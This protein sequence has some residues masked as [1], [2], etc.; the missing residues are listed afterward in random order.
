MTRKF[1]GIKVNIING[2][3][4]CEYEVGLNASNKMTG[5]P[6]FNQRLKASKGDDDSVN[7][8]SSILRST[9]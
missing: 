1:D 8:S 6:L 9:N 4:N 3:V 7:E 2:K 5:N